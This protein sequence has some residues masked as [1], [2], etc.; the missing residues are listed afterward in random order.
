MREGFFGLNVAVRGLY[1]AQR[2][3]DVVNHNLNNVNTPGFSRQRAVQAASRPMAIYDG[4]GMIGTGS[5]V[6]SVNRVRDE[7]LD[8]KYWSETVSYGEWAAKKEVLSDMEVTFNEPSNSGFTKVLGEFFSS[9]QELGKDPSSS[10]VR[11]L[12]REKGVTVAKYFNSTAV[13]FEK[14]QADVNYRIKTKVEEVN[15]LATQIQQLNRQIYVSELD[16]SNANDLRDRRTLLVDKMSGIVNIDANEVVVGKLPD[17]RDNKHFVVTISGKAIID[18]F[19]IS[20]LAVVQRG[21]T[22]KLN[23][24][25]IPQLYNVQWEDGNKLKIKGGELRGYLDIRDGNEGQIGMDGVTSSPMYK[26]IPFYM[27]KLNQFVRTFAMAFNEGFMDNNTNGMIDPGENGT[28]HADGYGLDPDG[29]GPLPV[30]TGIRFFTMLGDNRNAVSTS[31]FLNGAHLTVDDPATPGVDETIAAV[32]N[33]YSNITARNFAVSE[34]II[35]NYSNIAAS[36][37]AGEVGNIV[38]LNE[39]LKIRHNT[40]M[41]SEGAPEDFMKSLIATLGID[42]QQAIRYSDN[43]DI[44]V[45]QIENRRLSDSGVSMDEEMANMVKFQHAYNAA[46]RMVVTM[47]EIYDTLINRLGVG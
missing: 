26:G 16:G 22:N 39:V 24:E 41:F 28:G 12:V 8:F 15:S 2:N 7:Y 25:D 17:G 34:D 18:H 46:A 5:D 23:E 13:H 40:H 9:L 42:S 6:V 30:P 19:D 33:R 36:S 27:R 37:A 47:G 4:T 1:T 29:T 35:T 43:Q 45:K 11:A 21:D 44:I 10:A 3:L 20:K 31:A 38:N 32:V 14:L